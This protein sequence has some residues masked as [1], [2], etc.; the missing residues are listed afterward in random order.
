MTEL[1]ASARDEARAAGAHAATDVTGFGLLGHLHNLCRESGLAADL[2]AGSVPAIDGCE[3]LLESGDGVSGGA[4]RNEGWASSFA[5]FATDLPR[6]RRRL[7]VDPTTS[8]GLLA[9][10]PA[11]AEMPSSWSVVGRLREGRAG[12][13]AVV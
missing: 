5:T 12:E 10:V 2:D 4:R 11:H 9:A 7:L 1:N 6:W 3:Q 13:I 8:G